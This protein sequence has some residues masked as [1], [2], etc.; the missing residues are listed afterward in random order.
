MFPHLAP[1]TELLSFQ[2]AGR[3][4]ALAPLNIADRTFDQGTNRAVMLL[5]P[6][7]R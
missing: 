6:W 4:Q 5:M 2:Q 3:T 7:R 1:L